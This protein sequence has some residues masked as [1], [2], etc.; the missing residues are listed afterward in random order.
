M[1]HR[2]SSLL[3]SVCILSA[4]DTMLVHTARLPATL[5]IHVEV[6]P[7]RPPHDIRHENRDA[8]PFRL[9][10]LIRTMRGDEVLFYSVDV[11]G[12]TYSRVFSAE[13]IPGAEVLL[14][15]VRF[16]EREADVRY[17]RVDLKG[18]GRERVLLIVDE[19][20]VTVR[21]LYTHP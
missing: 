5:E 20:Q 17:G 15:S 8:D 10:V 13:D 4:C 3:V 18:R 7:I 21:H 11:V 1:A 14:I 16:L 6:D 9:E 19:H 2:I 12:F